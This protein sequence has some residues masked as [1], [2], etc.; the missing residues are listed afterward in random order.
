MQ[1]T[2]TQNLDITNLEYYR[3]VFFVVTESNS[4]GPHSFLIPSE[5][6][7]IAPRIFCTCS[8]GIYATCVHASRLIEHFRSN[9][10]AKERPFDHDDFQKGIFWK[11][12]MPFLKKRPIC[13]DA[14]TQEL[15][16]DD[17]RARLQVSTH[18]DGLIVDYYS[19][20]PDVRLN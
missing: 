18:S 19:T 17:N 9:L 4:T 1:T 14:L 2:S 7:K 15:L 8:P 16:S 6:N 13:F 3:N 12:L 20:K 5:G 11:L 10:S